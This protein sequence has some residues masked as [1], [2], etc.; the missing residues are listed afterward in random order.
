MHNTNNAPGRPWGQGH[1]TECITLANLH[2]TSNKNYNMCW[3]TLAV[4]MK[5]GTAWRSFM[6]IWGAICEASWSWKWYWLKVILNCSLGPTLIRASLVDHRKVH[7][8]H[9]LEAACRQE[10][11]DPIWSGVMLK[12]LSEQFSCP[13]T[14][15]KGNY[16][17]HWELHRHTASG[18]EYEYCPRDFHVGKMRWPGQA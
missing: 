12:P 17:P 4:F 8:T 14:A 11:G 7:L 16:L 15:L 2:Q 18:G 3:N 1:A 9:I 5:C 13:E 6:E 10:Y